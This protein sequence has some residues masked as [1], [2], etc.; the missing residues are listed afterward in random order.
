MS[1]RT[2]SSLHGFLLLDGAFTDANR[3][4]GTTA[5][6]ADPSPDQ[7]QPEGNAGYLELR[8][9]GDALENTEYRVQTVSPGGA[10]NTGA[11]GA[12][13]WRPTTSTDATDYRGWVAY[14]H[15]MDI[16][17]PTW[18]T[19]KD[20][21]A[22]RMSDGTV[23][24]GFTSFSNP[25]C[26]HRAP[27][28]S[29][30]TE[31]VI[32]S[33]VSITGGTSPSA[34]MRIPRDGGERA[35]FLQIQRR[36][37]H[38]SPADEW[39]IHIYAS[40]NK[41]ANWT[42]VVRGSR[43]FSLPNSA[44]VYRMTATYHDGYI[45]ALLQ[46]LD[47]GTTTWYHLVSDDM[48]ASWVQLEAV[49]ITQIRN[50]QAFT[51]PL[52]QVIILY[53]DG[54]AN[55][56][57]YVIKSTP[58]QKLVGNPT[59]GNSTQ[60]GN[61]SSYTYQRF[62]STLATDGRIYIQAR[63]TGANADN[64]DMWV[65]NPD[66]PETV[67]DEDDRYYLRGAFRTGDTTENL[68]QP[69][70]TNI[71]PPILVEFRD[72][73]LYLG[74]VVSNAGAYTA[75]LWLA[76]FGGYS[77]ID[78]RDVGADN[79][80]ASSRLVHGCAYIPVDVPSNWGNIT[81]STTGSPAE[82][83]TTGGRFRLQV[84]L[85][86]SSTYSAQIACGPAGGG[87]SMN[88]ILLYSG[89]NVSSGGFGTN[90]DIYGGG[91]WSDGTD[92]LNV[93]MRLSDTE[94]GLYNVTAA[95]SVFNATGI[96]PGRK[97]WML[98]SS[99]PGG[100]SATI[101]IYYRLFGEQVWVYVNAAAVSVSTSGG[102]TV[103]TLYIRQGSSVS[104]TDV[105]W[106]PAQMMGAQDVGVLQWPLSHPAAWPTAF[107]GRPFGITPHDLQAGRRIYAAGGPAYYGDAW[108]V[109]TRYARGLH[110]IDP[111]VSPSPNVYYE[112]TSTAEQV[113]EW[114][115][116]T[117]DRPLD[118]TIGI[119]LGGINFRTAYLEE[120][121]GA[122]WDSTA[123]ID[124]ATG[125]SGLSYTLSGVVLTA[126][127][128]GTAA[129]RYLHMDELSGCTVVLDTGGTPTAKR[130]TANSEGVWDPAHGRKPLVRLESTHGVTTGTCD[131]CASSVV[132]LIHDRTTARTK[133]RL[134]IP[135]NQAVPD[136]GYRIGVCVIGPMAYLP[137]VPDWGRQMEA[138]PNVEITES[139]D[140]RRFAT[141]R[142]RPR[143][144]VEVSWPGG[145]D[146]SHVYALD[147][148]YLEPGSGYAAA[149]VVNDAQKI[150]AMLLRADGSRIPAVYIARAPAPGSTTQTI[151]G[152]GTHLYGRL[153]DRV[154]RTAVL[155]DEYLSEVQT[156]DSI[157]IEEEV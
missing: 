91:Q 60:L 68:G 156:I 31:V 113:I 102:S 88:R 111:T 44:L 154:R 152:I 120:W 21:S 55:E 1:A 96:P 137:N 72:Q 122:S 20:L 51:T 76:A 114:D 7:P 157:T 124:A 112:S 37:V 138:R 140:G 94:V 130:A 132:V 39:G 139:R 129:G 141:R 17:R 149:G 58:Y 107:S 67:Y 136:P 70:G 80:A 118:G 153:S 61:R 77:S 147:P 24:V 50:P 62:W 125:T 52:G 84:P 95:T 146:T 87:A 155:G 53:R 71:S 66:Q 78:W 27:D 104:S 22:V 93:R 97:D 109:G 46:A 150:E 26:A 36:G 32:D 3:G 69:G 47:G 100:G 105:E 99:F 11:G 5:T 74:P 54:I 63:E 38:P 48:G 13:V 40:D 127:G 143:R 101:G 10:S 89:V 81:V 33:G 18:G 133:Y 9:V 135:A 57:R 2:P 30:W 106:G 98:V 73:M 12:Y 85:S 119:Y 16:Y 14:R 8:Q 123:T 19:A 64:I 82:S 92:L 34:L 131:L 59:L 86:P 42:Q 65:I 4:A 35:L 83:I 142:G 25:T 144:S 29:S 116:T 41:G 23:I 90:D 45:T 115:L 28:A 49:S 134:R 117:A 79:D 15:L 121:N 151:I 6:Q 75:N 148:D 110:Q 128:S 108:T 126:S 56:I 145:T 43:G 103:D